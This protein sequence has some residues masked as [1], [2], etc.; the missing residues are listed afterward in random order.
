LN[1][2]IDLGCAC[3]L[4]GTAAPENNLEIDHQEKIL[5]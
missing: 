1:K 2:H 4:A 3:A 5:S